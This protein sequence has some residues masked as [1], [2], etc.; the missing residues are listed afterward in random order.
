MLTRQPPHVCEL[1]NKKYST[2]RTLALLF[3]LKNQHPPKLQT[4]IDP[5]VC[6]SC[7]P[8]LQQFIMMCSVSVVSLKVYDLKKK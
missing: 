7:N 5:C 3:L 4:L 2:R 1:I 8:T 6:G